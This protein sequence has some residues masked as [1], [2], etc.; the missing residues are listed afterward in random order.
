V[1]LTVSTRLK[2]DLERVLIGSV[3]NSHIRQIFT[4]NKLQ[5]DELL[6]K[7]LIKSRPLCPRILHE[8]FRNT[9]AGGRLSFY[10]KSHNTRTIQE[11]FASDVQ[12]D[13]FHNEIE[14]LESNAVRHWLGMFIEIRNLDPVDPKNRNFLI[15]F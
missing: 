11:L 15:L 3:K 2:N 1:P 14:A 13:L 12:R 5:E 6:F 8:I 4:T 9:E 10:T 7:Y